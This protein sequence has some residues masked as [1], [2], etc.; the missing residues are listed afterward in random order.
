MKSQV[1]LKLFA[2]LQEFTPPSADNFI[3]DQGTRICD[4]LDQI[5]MP[6]EKAKLIFINGVKAELTTVL[7]GGERVGI[8]P[9]V[10]GG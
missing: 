4:L 8:F 9:P 1:Q 10:G 2:T 3:I 6:R 5:N 7:E